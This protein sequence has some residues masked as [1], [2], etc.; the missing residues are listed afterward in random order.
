MC[1]EQ[2][3]HLQEYIKSFVFSWSRDDVFRNMSKGIYTSSLTIAEDFSF[4]PE[5]QP[6]GGDSEC[7]LR[8][9]CYHRIE[10]V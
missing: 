10:W 9:L 4:P 5:L 2:F 8:L 1:F 7:W 3:T 6:L